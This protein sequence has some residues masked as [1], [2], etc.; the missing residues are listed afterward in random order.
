[1]CRHDHSVEIKY[2]GGRGIYLLIGYLSGWEVYYLWAKMF[3][4]DENLL[5]KLAIAIFK[6]YD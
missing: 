4:R 6:R 5:I 3:L 2:T 1:M